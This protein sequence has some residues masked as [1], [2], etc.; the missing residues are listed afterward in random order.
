MLARSFK[1]ARQLRIR[2]DVYDA[3]ILALHYFEREEPNHLDIEIAPSVILVEAEMGNPVPPPN[4]NMRCWRQKHDCGTVCCIGGT[5]E[6]LAGM[7]YASID[8]YSHEGPVVKLELMNLFYPYE[9]GIP[10]N[11]IT[12]AM[13]AQ[14]LSNYLTTGKSNWQEVV[15]A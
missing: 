5:A 14:A 10:W 9:I 4:F 12:V 1:T 15:A 11:Y 13:A 3:L 2:Q 7:P 6:M 8:R